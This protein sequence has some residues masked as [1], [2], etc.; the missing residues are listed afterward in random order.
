MD[1]DSSMAAPGL[2]SPMQVA[3]P[4]VFEDHMPIFSPLSSPVYKE[5]SVALD[6]PFM[7]SRSS[8]TF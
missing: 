5:P 7:S 4:S 8:P 6:D 3:I 2:H 1:V